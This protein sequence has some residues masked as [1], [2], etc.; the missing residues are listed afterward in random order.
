MVPTDF[1]SIALDGLYSSIVFA[2]LV[3][4]GAVAD[5]N[6]ASDIGSTHSRMSPPYVWVARSCRLPYTFIRY[7]AVSLA[8][9]LWYCTTPAPSTRSVT[10]GS[11]LFAARL[12]VKRFWSRLIGQ[13]KVE[14]C[15]VRARVQLYVR[16][17]RGPQFPAS[18]CARHASQCAGPF[19]LCTSTAQSRSSITNKDRICLCERRPGCAEHH[20]PSMPSDAGT[21]PSFRLR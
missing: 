9:C 13:E 17:W 3:A 7:S 18:D 6:S 15:G 4:A 5:A 21:A 11:S 14:G 12:R 19:R 2:L 8:R 1:S 20:S 16:S 10:V